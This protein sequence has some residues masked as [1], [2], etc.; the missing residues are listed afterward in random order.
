MF[1]KI[2]LYVG[3]VCAIILTGVGIHLEGLRFLY[4]LGIFVVCVTPAELIVGAMIRQIGLGPEA[5]RAFMILTAGVLGYIIAP[6]IRS[7]VGLVTI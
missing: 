7:L 4:Y 1:D 6:Y 3:A 5:V 2:L